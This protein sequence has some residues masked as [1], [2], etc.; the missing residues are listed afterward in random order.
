M[1]EVEFSSWLDRIKSVVESCSRALVEFV[2]RSNLVDLISL[3]SLFMVLVFPFPEWLFQITADLCLLLFLVRPRSIRNPLFWFSLALCASIGVIRDWHAVDNHKYLLLYWLWILFLCHLLAEPQWQ[4]RI[5][6]FNARFFLCFVFLVS[7]AQKLS[8][9]TYRSGEMFE[10]Y[11][12]ADSRFTAF[13]KLI[14]IDPSV[15]DAVQ[16]RIALFRS[17]YSKPE[18]DELELPGID[19]ARI[20]ALILTWWDALLQLSIGVLLFFA[21]RATDQLGHI[22]LLI[23]IFTTYLPAPIFGFGWILAVMGLTLAKDNFPKIAAVYML[24][25]VA[26]ILYQIPWRDWVLGK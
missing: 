2:A 15:P 16:K 25:F 5:L 21:L 7:G 22:L 26:V 9:P 13:G 17:P 20:A 19:R 4:R 1:S 24:S 23:F 14:G 3:L 8:S 11:L 18:N 10:Y 6:L 12:Y